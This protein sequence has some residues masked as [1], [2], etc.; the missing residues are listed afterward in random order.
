MGWL[1][2][3]RFDLP[4]FDNF[5]EA[6]TAILSVPKEGAK[7]IGNYLG[8]LRL[9]YFASRWFDK[10]IYFSQKFNIPVGGLLFKKLK[11]LP[12]MKKIPLPIN[13]S[14]LTIKNG[15]VAVLN[16][17]Y[18]EIKN[19]PPLRDFPLSP[20]VI[21]ELDNWMSKN[22]VDVDKDGVSEI[23]TSIF[24]IDADD[25]PETF[26]LHYKTPARTVRKETPLRL[27]TGITFQTSYEIYIVPS[28][29][30]KKT[31]N[32]TLPATIFFYADI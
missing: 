29:N 25:K 8:L 13:K 6:K 18:G 10:K 24:R 3:I 1:D 14:T 20:A 23:S 2:K 5:E 15:R 12:G 7:E 16:T 27:P 28:A 32:I 22:P 21:T 9:G 4:R 30:P 19:K 17:P 31:I 11:S 26:Y